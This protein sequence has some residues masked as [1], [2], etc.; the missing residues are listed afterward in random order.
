MQPPTNTFLCACVCSLFSCWEV[1]SFVCEKPGILLRF[2]LSGSQANL[3]YGTN[4]GF[5][6]CVCVCLSLGSGVFATGV[7][8]HM[9]WVAR[10]FS[11]LP[12]RGPHTHCVL[13]F[14]YSL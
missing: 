12:K 3:L 4:V 2:A 14:I 7:L 8:E 11:F 6:G 13:S 1:V 10:R 9:A 5:R